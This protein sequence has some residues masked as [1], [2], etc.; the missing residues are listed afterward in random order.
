[1]GNGK[2]SYTCLFMDP[3]FC[4]GG[5]IETCSHSDIDDGQVSADGI[6]HTLNPHTDWK[7]SWEN[8]RIRCPEQRVT[9]PGKN[10]H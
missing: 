1:M 9:L 3:K 8:G 7:L 5:E 2:V 10:L 6:P 4:V